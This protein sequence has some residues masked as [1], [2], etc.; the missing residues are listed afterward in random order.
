MSLQGHS[1]TFEISYD[2]ESSLI[3]GKKVNVR[4]FLKMGKKENPSNC[5]L[6]SITSVFGKIIKQRPPGSHFQEYAGQESDW[7]EPV[8]T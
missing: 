5:R 7:E 6:V 4:F 8:W 2:K 3:F 1:V